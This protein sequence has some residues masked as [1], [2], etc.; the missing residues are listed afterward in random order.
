MRLRRAF[1]PTLLT[2]APVIVLAQTPAAQPPAEET[3]QKA[4]VALKAGGKLGWVEFRADWCGWCKKMEKFFGEGDTAAVLKKY[5][6]MIPIDYEKAAGAPQLSARLGEKGNE[7]LPWFAVVDAGGKPLATSE[8]PKGNIG[9]PGN[10]VE[11]AHFLS[12]LR[13]TAKGITPGE[14]SLIEKALQAK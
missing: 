1:L 11:N 3:F 7:G 13:A 4:L 10:D 8:G 6:L 5:Y 9:F 2:L 12:V 14:L